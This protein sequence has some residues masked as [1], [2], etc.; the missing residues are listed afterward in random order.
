MNPWTC[1]FVGVIFAA[2]VGL[3]VLQSWSARST[4]IAQRR[5]L[6]DNEFVKTFAAA[7]DDARLLLAIRRAI[8]GACKVPA[9]CILPNENPRKLH[10]L[11]LIGWDALD[12]VFRLEIDLRVKLGG[13]DRDGFDE[14]VGRGPT[15]ADF[16][17]WMLPEVKK[18]LSGPTARFPE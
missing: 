3:M 6:P 5:P 18:H 9:E 13:F 1:L 14:A 16:I 12:I 2:L 17:R 4:F 15:L 11:M 10:N 7:E 8:A